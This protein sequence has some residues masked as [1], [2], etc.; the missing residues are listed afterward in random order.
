[1]SVALK[2]QALAGGLEGG[3]GVPGGAH[4]QRRRGQADVGPRWA[5]KISRARNV[6]HHTYRT[7]NVE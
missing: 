5:H 7:W 1:M 3:Q 2:A 6:I 4:P